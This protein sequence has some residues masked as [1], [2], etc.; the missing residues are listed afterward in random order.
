MCGHFA[1]NYI[2][3]INLLQ[4]YG[5]SSASDVNIEEFMSE[6]G[7][8]PSQGQTN[9]YIPVIWVKNSTR[10]LDFFR[11]D[12][13]PSWWKKPLSEKKFA[14]YN[15]R[16]E[17]LKEKAT[18][19]SAWGK[20]QRCIIPATEFFEWPDKKKVP[21]GMQRREHKITLTDQKI[22]SMAGIYDECRI[23]GEYLRSCTII[24][25]GANRKIADIPHNRMPV[26]L[27]PQYEDLWLS[28]SA[29]NREVEKLLMAYPAEKINVFV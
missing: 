10:T 6:K 14:T 12:I 19:R 7:F 27:S 18:F 11:W 5:I 16:M 25:T 26:I 15:A 24:T 13:V 23:D 21:A 17:T 29:E 4:R 20:K 28:E 8:Y 9:S 3:L 22:F 2:N 1:L